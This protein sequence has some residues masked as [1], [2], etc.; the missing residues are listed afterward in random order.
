[1]G[2]RE[3]ISC[4]AVSSQGDD[5]AARAGQ[6]AAHPLLHRGKSARAA[7]IALNQRLNDVSRLL[8]S[9]PQ[10][11][12]KIAMAP[13]GPLSSLRRTWSWPRKVLVFPVRHRTGRSKNVPADLTS[14]P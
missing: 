4:R 11:A 7:E 2:L 1:H 14:S 9:F 12:V 13:I 3:G 10:A 8:E 5:R 6:P